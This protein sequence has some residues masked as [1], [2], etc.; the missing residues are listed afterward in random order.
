MK[1]KR[2]IYYSIFTLRPFF[3]FVMASSQLSYVW[4]GYLAQLVKPICLCKERVITWISGIDNNYAQVEMAD[5]F[6]R[7]LTYCT[8]LPKTIAFIYFLKSSRNL[9]YLFRVFLPQNRFDSL[10][11][12]L[13]FDSV[14]QSIYSFPWWALMDKHSVHE[15]RFFFVFLFR[16]HS[17]EGD[18]STQ[19]Q[20]VTQCQGI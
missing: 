20:I 3:F 2:K 7:E 14:N 16:F 11:P 13:D 19:T 18:K 10:L 15:T 5:F 8:R 4:T 17:K 9:R 1:N 12:N 6:V